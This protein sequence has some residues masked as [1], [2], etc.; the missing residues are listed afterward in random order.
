MFL[1][2]TVSPSSEGIPKKADL[3]IWEHDLGRMVRR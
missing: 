1:P 2:E 3:E